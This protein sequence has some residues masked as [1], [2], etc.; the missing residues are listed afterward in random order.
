MEITPPFRRFPFKIDSGSSPGTGFSPVRACHMFCQVTYSK[1]LVYHLPGQL[2]FRCLTHYGIINIKIFPVN[3]Y[4]DTG[5]LFQLTQLLYGEF[6]LDSSAAH[7][8]MDI[9]DPV[10]SQ[11]VINILGDIRAQQVVRISHKH[12]CNIHRYIA[13]AYHRYRFSVKRPHRRGTG[14]SVIPLYKTCCAIYS[15]QAAPFNV[16]RTVVN[17]TGGKDHSIVVSPK[18]FKRYIPPE[19]DVCEKPDMRVA[20]RF[21]ECGSN[22]SDCRMVRG[23]T[24]PYEAKRD[25]EL[26]ENINIRFGGKPQIRTLLLELLKQNIR[27]IYPGRARPYN[28]RTQRPACHAGGILIISHSFYTILYSPVTIEI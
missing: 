15:S 7:K 17:S 25:G 23:N 10:C 12:A 21:I 3:D 8:N 20:E 9:P 13:A 18:V 22:E 16:Q 4:P 28:G 2:I 27:G 11:P 6:C 24:I 26:F 5:K 19:F 1:Q 14:I